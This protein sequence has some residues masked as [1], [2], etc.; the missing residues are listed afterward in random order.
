MTTTPGFPGLLFSRPQRLPSIEAPESLRRSQGS[1]AFR[2]LVNSSS[3]FNP[4]S[5]ERASPRILT[6]ALPTM[7]P[8]APQP[9]TWNW[10]TIKL[11]WINKLIKNYMTIIVWERERERGHKS[12]NEPGRVGKCWA[13]FILKPKPRYLPLPGLMSFMIQEEGQ[14]VSHAQGLRC[15]NR[16]Q[17]A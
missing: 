17:Q 7:T 2:D 4:S 10:G 9:A 1:A 16:Q 6:I 13:S 12:G 8:S 15:Q 3:S 14:P 11:M 5:G